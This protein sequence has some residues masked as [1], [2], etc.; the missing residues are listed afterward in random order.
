MAYTSDLFFISDSIVDTK[1]GY[2][3]LKTPVTL[4]RDDYSDVSDSDKYMYIVLY[5]G[6]TNKTE[7][8]CFCNN[9][10]KLNP[11]LKLNEVVFYRTVFSKKEEI[12]IPGKSRQ[13][14]HWK[15]VFLIKSW[16]LLCFSV[17]CSYAVST[18]I[19]TR[20]KINL[21]DRH[22]TEYMTY[23]FLASQTNVIFTS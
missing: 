19:V 3:W 20:M 13:V 1:P 16:H 18:L 21:C 17:L 15:M 6:L 11:W 23:F 2:V 10:Y 8:Y 7:K 22:N 14:K 12:P 5:L 4:V 9:I